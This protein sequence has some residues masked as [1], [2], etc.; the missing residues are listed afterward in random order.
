[1]ITDALIIKKDPLKQI[2]EEGK[3]WEIRGTKTH[4]RGL[5]ALIQSRSGTIV[6]TAELIDCIGPLSP[7]EYNCNQKKLK[8]R[9]LKS[10]SDLYYKNTYAWVLKNAKRLKTPKK[11][12]HKLGVI[13]WHP[14]K[15]K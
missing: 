8:G 4:K 5:I 13:I 2:F 12:T 15:L 14:V 6:G 11:Y 7:N 10:K 1:M 9:K 3:I